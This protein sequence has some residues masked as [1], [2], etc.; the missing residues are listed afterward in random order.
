[1]ALTVPVM[2][3]QNFSIPAGYNEVITFD[4]NPAVTPS[5]LH[6]VIFWSVYKQQFGI[7]S[8][9]PILTKSSLASPPPDI[10]GIDSPLSFTVQMHTADT[11]V[12]LRNYYHEASIQNAAGE[13]IGGSWGIMTVTP[14]ENRS[15]DAGLDTIPPTRPTGLVA[16]P[17]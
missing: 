5:L 7:P 1:M 4:V 13:V 9:L 11:L 2:T 12:L 16:T 17:E 6:T 10:V 14:T 15:I 3:P 8:G